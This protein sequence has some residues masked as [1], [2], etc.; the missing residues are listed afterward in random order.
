MTLTDMVLDFAA[1]S[2]HDLLLDLGQNCMKLRGRLA[3]KKI[4]FFAE[5]YFTLVKT[6]VFV[7]GNSKN[8]SN[9]VFEK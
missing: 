7:H 8:I 3:I 5:N 6:M 1:I 2:L 9:L 4:H